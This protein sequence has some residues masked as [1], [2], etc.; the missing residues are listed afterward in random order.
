MALAGLNVS[1]L[2]AA[3]AI[4]APVYGLPPSRERLGIA[5]ALLLRLKLV[6]DE[7]VS[8]LDVSVQCWS[9]VGTLYYRAASCL[10]RATIWVGS[11]KRS[12]IRSQN[13]VVI[14]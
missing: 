10:A 3:I 13:S 5:R 1:F 4:V 6:V 2:E 11:T 12:A 14:M 8:A 9:A 7:P